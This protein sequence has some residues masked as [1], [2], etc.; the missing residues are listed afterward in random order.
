MVV[1]EDVRE[2]GDTLN[3]AH[4]SGHHPL[5]SLCLSLA[6]SEVLALVVQHAESPRLLG[7]SVQQEV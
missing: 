5:G 6:G 1:K 4:V 2:T 3:A 7:E